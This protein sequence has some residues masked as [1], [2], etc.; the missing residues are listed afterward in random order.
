MVEILFIGTRLLDKA[1]KKSTNNHAVIFIIT[2]VITIF[3]LINRKNIMS[4]ITMDL[5]I[6]ISL[7]VTR[8]TILIIGGLINVPNH[9]HQIIML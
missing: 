8:I 4:H 5:M 9:Y 2:Y 1:I 3:V 7:I 6:T